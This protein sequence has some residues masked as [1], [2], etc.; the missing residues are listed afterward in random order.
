[1][2]VS[3]PTTD[4]VAVANDAQDARINTHEDRLVA[5]QA[6]IDDLIAR[7]AALEAGSTT[8]PPPDIEEPPDTEEPPG[9]T[10][11]AVT[12]H[13]DGEDYVYDPVDGTNLGD[14]LDPAG[15]FIMSCIRVKAADC[16]LVLDFRATDA[17]RSVVV[18]YSDPL[19]GNCPNLAYSVFIEGETIDIPDHYAN[20]AWRWQ[21]CPWPHPLTP[22]ETLYER[23]LLP[24]HDGALACGKAGNLSTITSAPPLSLCGFTP[25]MGMTGGRADI[26]TV[27]GWQAEWMCLQGAEML[28][29]IIVQGEAA[30]PWRFRDTTT[31]AIFDAIKQYPKASLF[32]GSGPAGDP[33]LYHGTGKHPG[34]DAA[35]CPSCYYVPYLLTGD[36]YFLELL[37]G[38]TMYCFMEIGRNPQTVVG[39]EQIRGVAWSLRNLFHCAVATPDEVPPWILPRSIFVDELERQRTLLEARQSDGYPYRQ[40]AHNIDS[41]GRWEMAW[42][43]HDYATS[44]I[45]WISMHDD[46]WSQQRDYMVQGIDGRSDPNSGWCPGYPT[47]YWTNT[48][49]KFDWAPELSFTSWAEAWDWNSK[50][51]Y[52]DTPGGVCP[53]LEATL[54]KNTSYDYFSAMM[55]ALRLG[56]QAGSEKAGVVLDRLTD[57]WEQGLRQYG[58]TEYKYCAAMEG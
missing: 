50:N 14:Y 27:T 19:N 39:S 44:I 53:T 17:W 9:E 46:R 55:H 22:L 21:S 24:R 37:H 29:T 25:E 18:E 10:V 7:V 49:A 38:E 6:E 15:R 43:Q 30:F 54:S 57:A 41:Y 34:L 58:Y 13:W 11:L 47:S 42:W 32:W 8:E 56:K 26:G 51:K 36:P 33:Q 16:P 20:A 23:R 35:H 31:G 1:M 48:T 52:T 5:Q 40:F 3:V 2:P 12:V 45:A 4:E 28:R